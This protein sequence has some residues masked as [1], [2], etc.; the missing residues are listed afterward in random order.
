MASFSS[1]PDRFVDAP[2]FAVVDTGTTVDDGGGRWPT[3][4]IDAT[5]HPEISDLGRVHAVEGIGDIATEAVLLDVD[6]ESFLPG[7]AEHV[8]ALAVIISAPVTAA[9]VVAFALPAHR[10]VL[11]AAAREGHLVIATTDPQR[12][13]ADEPLWLAI[14]LDPQLLAD[15]LPR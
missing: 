10:E 1:S 2:I 12:A 6:E 9:F 4:V 14:D 8:L 11:D 13:S 15:V 7:S 3:A 5:G